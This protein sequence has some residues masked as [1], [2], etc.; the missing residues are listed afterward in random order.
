MAH[1]KTHL[2]TM[3]P[4]CTEKHPSKMSKAELVHLC[5]TIN[6]EKGEIAVKYGQ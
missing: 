4:A 5:S 1:P 6:A 3:L 2:P